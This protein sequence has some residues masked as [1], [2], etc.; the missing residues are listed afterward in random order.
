MSM[1]LTN[2]ASFYASEHVR[3]ERS[4]MRKGMSAQTA[5]DIVQEAFVRVM[6]HSKG[7]IRHPAAYLHKT[8]NAVIIDFYR[9]E[10]SSSQ[11]VVLNAEI[12]QS[13]ADPAPLADAHMVSEEEIAL[14][15]DAIDNLPARS[16]EVLLL[17]RFEGLSYNEISLRL[18]ISKNTVMVHMVKAVA[19]LKS[20]LNQKKP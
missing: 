9:K 1:D 11:M 13:I 2:I 5:A 10:R 3:L 7:D 17:H 15:T 4:L 12:E 18:G 14:L 16:R 8:L 6:R 19:V 20:H